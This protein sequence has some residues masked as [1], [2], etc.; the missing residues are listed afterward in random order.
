VNYS[1]GFKKAPPESA[2]QKSQKERWRV[3]YSGASRRPRPRARPKRARKSAKAARFPV[4]KRRRFLGA[5]AAYPK[6]AVGEAK[7]KCV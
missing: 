1:R 2:A 4:L 6:G 7:A 3:N 5:E